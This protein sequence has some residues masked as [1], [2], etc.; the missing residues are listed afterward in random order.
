[1]LVQRREAFPERG[2]HSGRPPRSRPPRRAKQR[3]PPQ[4]QTTR[5]RPRN[6]DAASVTAAIP[7]RGVHV[8]SAGADGAADPSRVRGPSRPVQRHEPART[9]AGLL[10][11]GGVDPA[12]G[13]TS[14]TTLLKRAPAGTS[15]PADPEAMMEHRPARHSGSNSNGRVSGNDPARWRDDAPARAPSGTHPPLTR[16]QIRIRRTICTSVTSPNAPNPA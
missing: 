10:P 12:F 4:K 9:R 5:D 7:Y 11:L 2:C 3:F 8:Q 1:M 6:V 13:A 14:R 16:P 15:P